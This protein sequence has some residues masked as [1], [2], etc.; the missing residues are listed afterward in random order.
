[1]G[2]IAPGMKLVRFKPVKCH[3]GNQRF[4]SFGYYPDGKKQ[5]NLGAL[6]LSLMIC[7]FSNTDVFVN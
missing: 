4:G 6:G 1:M 3:F 2:V 7:S 5:S